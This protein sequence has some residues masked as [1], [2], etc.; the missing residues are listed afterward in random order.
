MYIYIYIHT[1]PLAR[2]QA[3]LG[4]ARPTLGLLRQC[5]RLTPGSDGMWAAASREFHE[6]GF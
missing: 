4:A 1:V 5:R 2:R 6:A 3:F